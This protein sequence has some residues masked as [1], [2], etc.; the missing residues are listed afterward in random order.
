VIAYGRGGV[1]ESI[2]GQDDDVPTGYFFDEQTP[3]AVID[4]VRAFESGAVRI[5]AAACRANALRFAPAR[6]RDEMTRVVD[7]AVADHARA[8]AA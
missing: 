8:L 5:S 2:R 7:G 4:A 6:F 1:P 3:E